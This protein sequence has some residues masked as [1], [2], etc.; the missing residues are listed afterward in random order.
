MY[1]MIN[2]VYFI[3]YLKECQSLNS[4]R[5]PDKIA[6]TFSALLKNSAENTIDKISTKYYK[7]KNTESRI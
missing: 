6:H 7:I 3:L 5:L 1:K 2:L 4:G